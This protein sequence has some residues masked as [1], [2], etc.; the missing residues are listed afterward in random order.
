MPA[1]GAIE[2]KDGTIIYV[3]IVTHDINYKG[4]LRRLVLANNITER[5]A[6][7]EKLKESY[8]A[9]RTLTG[10]SPKCQGRGAIEYFPR[11]S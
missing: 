7:E 4:Q 3:D 2:K 6:A 1:S 5:H 11:D 10:V 9:I 8:E